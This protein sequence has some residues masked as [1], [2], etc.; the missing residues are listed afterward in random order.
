MA[1]QTMMFGEYSWRVR[2]QEKSGPGPNRWE[3]GNVRLD[4]KK[5]LHFHIKQDAKGWACAEVT[6]EKRL[7]FGLYEFQIIGPIGRF[8]PNIVLGLFNYPPRDA[9]PGRIP[10]TGAGA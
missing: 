4:D 9:G 5:H 3:A 2:S 10:A 7:H 8:D 6:M 1:R